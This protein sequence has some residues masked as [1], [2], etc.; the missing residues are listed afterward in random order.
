MPDELK[1]GAHVHLIGIG[2]FGINPIARVMHEFG[3]SVS[4]C[5][6]APSPLLD[7]LY[8]MGIPVEI[9]HR[10][11]HLD[12]YTPDALI[13]SSAIPADNVEVIAASRRGIPVLKRADVLCTLMEGRTG[14]AVAGTHGKTTTSAMLAWALLEAGL[15]PSFIVGGVLTN[16]DTNARA[17]GGGPFVIEADEY[18]RMFMGLCPQTA[19]VT[20]IEMDHPDMF[21]SLAEVRA[22]FQE[23]VSLLPEDG[24]LIAGYDDPEARRLAEVASVPALTYGLLGGDWTADTV[25][26]NGR[27][28]M[29][30]IALWHGRPIAEVSLR[31]PGVHNVQNALGVLAAAEAFGAPVEDAAAALGE[32]AGVGRRFEVKGEAQDVTVVDDYAHHPTAIQA[33]IAAAG[34][35]FPGS[36]IWAVWQPHTYSRTKAL[37]DEFAASFV[38]ADHV[39]ITDV[40]RSRDTSTFGVGPEDVLA[41]MT[42]HRDAQHIG[43]LDD[44]VDYLALNVRPGDVVL[45]LSAGDATRVCDD[46]LAELGGTRTGTGA[47]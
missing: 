2:G 12:A 34:E 37:L 3:Y 19:L 14:V 7:P 26:P 38:D 35:R 18:D 5:D 30:F 16:L 9:G 29:D 46:L 36:A 39:I 45:V 32:F 8:E 33:T 20:M 1:P 27:G 23:F 11:A 42:Y 43:P 4:G 22:L 28:G 6:A 41:R 44:V 40:F 13:V 47:A 10:A 31:V 25:T 17:G 24:L 15:D 21:A